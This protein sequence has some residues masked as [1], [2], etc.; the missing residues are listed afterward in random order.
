MRISRHLCI[1]AALVLCLWSAL[2]ARYPRFFLT[3]YL[4]GYLAGLALCALQGYWE[5]AAGRPTSHY[6]RVYNFLCFNDGYHAEHHADP[7]V[8]WTALPH[9]PEAGAAASPWP[10][11]LRWLDLRPLEVLERLVLHSARL[12]RFVLRRHRRAFQALLPQA[13][14]I[15]RV[16][17]V[18]GG[19]YPRTALILRE[20]LPA[21]HLTIVD[22]NPRNL[23]TARA[24]LDENIEYRNQRYLPG[25]SH[26]CDLTVIPLCL[27]GDRA[28]IYRHPP[29]PAVLVHDWIWRRR[30]PRS[31]HLPPPPQTPQP[32]RAGRFGN[33]RTDCQSVQASQARP[34]TSTALL[35]VLLLAKLIMIWP[36]AAPS[37]R[38]V[39]VGLHLAGRLRSPRLRRLRI[40]AALANRPAVLL[41]ASPL[42]RHQHPRG[43]RSLHAPHTPHAAR[44][45]RAAGRFHPALRHPQPT[46]PSSSPYSRQ[47]RSC[48]ASSAHYRVSGSSPSSRSRSWDP[49]PAAVPTHAA[50]T[51]TPSPR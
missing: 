12:Q 4:P 8:H 3:V 10:P 46:S 51:A 48:R 6:G 18:G 37:D 49:P 36:H 17:I 22:S 45:T 26:D 24:F 15:R 38:L 30:E 39:P 34:N 29:S 23:Q 42:H 21:A 31:R 28:A 32:D 9:R 47:P 33:L 2:A 43:T 27:R 20:L 44:R 35:L 13:G 14:D 5:H 11:L 50:W 19:L 25:E 1:E 7:A 40:R 16:T 41:G